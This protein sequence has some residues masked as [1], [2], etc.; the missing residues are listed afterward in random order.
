MPKKKLRV[1]QT[2]VGDPTFLMSFVIE[3]EEGTDDTTKL[4]INVTIGEKKIFVMNAS[5]AFKDGVEND[6]ISV[7]DASEENLPDEIPLNITFTFDDGEKTEFN[8]PNVELLPTRDSRL[9]ASQDAVLHCVSGT[10]LYA[11][12]G[13]FN[14]E[15]L[16]YN[17]YMSTIWNYSVVTITTS[18]TRVGCYRITNKQTGRF[19][20][21]VDDRAIFIDSD[22]DSNAVDWVLAKHDENP[23]YSIQHAYTGK[24]FIA[25]M[26]NSS[27]TL[28]NE[29]GYWYFHIKDN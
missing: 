19:F 12:M 22:D 1:S 21:V 18:P 13:E 17:T 20:A 16:C 2:G 24:Y 4:S 14:E 23:T 27:T 29:P 7:F 9:G 25:E 10:G 26:N 8:Y 6:V 5:G 28:T 15:A 3:P 11:L